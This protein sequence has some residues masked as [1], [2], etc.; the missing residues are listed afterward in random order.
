LL[1]QGVKEGLVASP[2]D[3]PGVHGA[4][5]LRA[6]N[7]LTGV[8]HDRTAEY[9]A[10][11][12]G[13]QVRSEDFIETVTLDLAPLPCWEGLPLAEQNRRVSELVRG[14]EVQ[15]RVERQGS[16]VLGRT[17]VLAV[18]PHQRPK[19]FERRAVP[20]FHA[21]QREVRERLREAYRLF[22]ERYRE[23]SLELREGNREAVF[24]GG[25]FPP[26]LPWIPAEPSPRPP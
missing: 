4:K 8:W 16:P 10:R 22:L 14:V 13:R 19:T 3:W 5:A 17:R 12:T 26:G 25:C 1:S 9:K 11:R 18:S 15:G 6:G 20:R 21:V 2:L 7:Q 24:P 23:A